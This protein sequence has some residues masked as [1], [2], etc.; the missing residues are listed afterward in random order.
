MANP[1][2]C[3]LR[4]VKLHVSGFRKHR[5]TKHEYILKKGK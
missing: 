3:L 5:Q 4:Y 1:T 2:V